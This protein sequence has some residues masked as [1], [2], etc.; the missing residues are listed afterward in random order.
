MVSMDRVGVG[1]TLP[2]WSVSEPSPLRAELVAAARD[3]RVDHSALTDQ[4]SSDHW[5]FVREGLPGV[6][7]GGTSYGA[8]H[9]PADV[10]SVVNRAQLERTARTVLSWLR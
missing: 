6:R 4:R 10:P 8:Y 7:I 9:S 3:A 5:S 1:H 2:I